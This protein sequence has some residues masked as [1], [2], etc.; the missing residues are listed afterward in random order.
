M[1]DS[2]TRE[3]LY[4]TTG[5]WTSDRI[6]D[7]IDDRAAQFPDR[8]LFRFEDRRISYRD[9]AAWVTSVAEH[10]VAQGVVRGDR[11]LVQLPNRLETLVLQIAAFRI[12]AIDV[13]VIPI[14][15]QHETRQ[16]IADVRPAVVAVAHTLG[17]RTP[18]AEIDRLLGELG[19]EPT[20]KI[21][22][23]GSAA[24]WTQI[25][26]S[27]SD[28]PRGHL[29]LPEPVDADEPALILYT[30][31][32][33]SAPKGALLTSRALF[34]HL[35]NM[36]AVADLDDRSV[37]AAGT[38]LSHL[39]GFVAG[40][41][42]PAFLGARSVIL[43]GWNPDQAVGVIEDERVTMMMGAT[44]FLRDLVTR[45]AA[46]NSPVHRLTNYLCAGAAIPRELIRDAEDVGV[47][48]TRNYGMTETA[49]ICTG[50]RRSDP[51]DMRADWDGRVLPGM[52][53][54]ASDERRRPLP[55]GAEGELRIRGAQLFDG[56]TDPAA[57]A[58]QFD[59]DGWFYP[60]DIGVVSDGW[61]RMTGR[62][63]DIVNRGG[64][65][66]STQDIEQALL[67]HRDVDSAAVCA[68]PDAR[69]GEAVGAW[70]ALRPGV[71]WNG[72]ETFL[73]H[74]DELGLA[75]AKLPTEWHVVKR[76]PTS[77]SGKVQ[78]FG[79]QELTDLATA[80]STRF[81]PARP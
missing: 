71:P 77:A 27:V 24:G 35:R 8:E 80:T 54:E 64:E 58:A 39:G 47:H 50:A 7:L 49:G 62:S 44:V 37:V 19:H 81:I 10:M 72:P 31:G 17:D 74:L 68:I 32:T 21:V 15:R 36:T 69:F 67:G 29:V 66:F 42:L 40:L 75:K 30:S 48:A 56:Y 76:I 14:Y 25:P 9:F 1:N 60:G 22:V 78:K 26:D 3:Q 43:P 59:E 4:Q 6:G 28:C 73:S 70:I 57:T 63:K 18:T 52:E 33:T 20:L 34:A 65:K 55:D 11:I 5:L 53:I 12:G 13:P 46:G 23:G 2:A 16:I 51:L 61:V 45:Y 38:P 41:I 79:L